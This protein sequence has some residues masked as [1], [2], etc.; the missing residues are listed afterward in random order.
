MAITEATNMTIGTAIAGKAGPGDWTNRGIGQALADEALARDAKR[1]YAG[2]R[3]PWPTPTPRKR[4]RNRDQ[5]D[6][7]LG[8]SSGPTTE[9]C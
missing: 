8:K 1:V 7:D 4:S 2:T 5:Y 6:P 3:R 9:P